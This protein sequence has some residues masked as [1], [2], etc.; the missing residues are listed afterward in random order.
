[1]EIWDIISLIVGIVVGIPII[2]IIIVK[3]FVEGQVIGAVLESFGVHPIIIV[4][5]GILGLIAL[6][7]GIISVF[8]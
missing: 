1:L 4:I 2:A 5:V 6:V 3:W 7:R 8:Q